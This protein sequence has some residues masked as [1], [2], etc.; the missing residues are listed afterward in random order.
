MKAVLFALN[1]KYIHSNLAIR[2]L[3]AYAAKLFPV[4]ICEY[5]INQNLDDILADLYRR[6]PD[7]IGFSCYIFNVEPTLKLIS[8]L[9]K[10]LPR[11]RILLGGPETSY[12]AKELL[13]YYPEIDFIISGEGEIPF[14][15]LLKQAG[16]EQGDFSSIPALHY[17]DGGQGVQTEEVP[18]LPA[19]RL[20]G[21]AAALSQLLEGCGG[22]IAPGGDGGGP[23]SQRRQ[24]Q[25]Q[26][27]AYMDLFH[28]YHLTD[29]PMR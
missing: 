6:Q 1:A 4:E 29:K 7:L 20:L 9:K 11:C 24:Q 23:Q 19:Q 27:S 28:W 22:R 10:L 12:R 18:Q 5:T 25:G 3:S 2:S 14:F 13:E 16:S 8:S 15:S 26:E 21:Q 17:R